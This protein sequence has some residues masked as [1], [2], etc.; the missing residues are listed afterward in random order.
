MGGVSVPFE[1]TRSLLTETISDEARRQAAR[2]DC[3]RRGNKDCWT[4]G[5]CELDDRDAYL[6]VTV[7]EDSLDGPPEGPG[8]QSQSQSRA[9]LD[10]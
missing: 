2:K 7:R 8:N 4:Q 3:L 6:R 9:V 5:L 1:I 10:K